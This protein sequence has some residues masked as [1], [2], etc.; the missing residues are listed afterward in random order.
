MVYSI[1]RTIHN[2][3]DISSL[4]GWCRMKFRIGSLLLLLMIIIPSLTFGEVITYNMYVGETKALSAKIYEENG[5]EL[6]SDIVWFSSNTSVAK[7]TNGVITAVNK[8]T[9]VISYNSK[10]GA[11]IHSGSVYVN[12]KSTVKSVEITLLTDSIRVGETQSTSVTVEAIPNIPV[13]AVTDVLYSSTDSSIFTVDKKGEI[14]GVNEGTAYLKV[15]TTDSARKDIIKV[16]VVSTVQ[17]VSIDKTVNKIHVGEKIQLETI[18]YPENAYLQ[19]VTWK[20]TNHV[21]ID[22]KGMATGLKEGTAYVSVYTVDGAKS[23]SVKFEVESMV[24]GIR[25]EENLIHISG[26][27]KAYQLNAVLLQ[28]K[29]GSYPYN[30]TI[31]WKSSNT[32]VASVSS[33]GLV[34]AKKDGA[35]NI[36]ATT[37]DGGYTAVA[38]VTIN[39]PDAFEISPTGVSLGE[40]S[41]SIQSGNSVIVP[42]S[43]EPQNTTEDTLDI[44]L[45][46]GDGTV[47]LKDGFVECTGYDEGRY[48]LKIT[49]ENGH[50]ATTTFNVNSN[51]KGVKIKSDALQR[52]S[53][54]GRYTLYL[55]QTGQLEH[56]LVKD[57]PGSV[58]LVDDVSWSSTDTKFVSVDNNGIYT[59]NRVGQTNIKIESKDSNHFDYLPV[60]VI[61]MAE[62]VS[63]PNHANIGLNMEYTPIPTFKLK[64]ELVGNAST[65]L[66]Q[67]YS[68]TLSSV[69]V[70]RVFIEAE[71]AFE[72]ERKDSLIE[73]RKSNILSDTTD[74]EYELGK[75]RSRLADLEDLLDQTDIVAD[76]DFYYYVEIKDKTQLTDRNY[77]TLAITYFTNGGKSIGSKLVS[78]FVIKI[79]TEDGALEDEMTIYA[80]GNT[81]EL[82][83]FDDRGNQIEA[84]LP[85]NNEMLQDQSLLMQSTDKSNIISDLRQGYG[86]LD[87]KKQPSDSNLIAVDDAKTLGLIQESFKS[88]YKRNITKLEMAKLCIAI[89][90]HFEKEQPDGF[91]YNVYMDTT[92]S[93]AI[94]AYQYGIVSVSSERLFYP[95]KEITREEMTYMFYK[96]IRALSMSIDSEKT[97]SM[98]QYFVDEDKI[99]DKFKKAVGSLSYQHSIVEGITENHF[100]PQVPNQIDSTLRYAV[101]LMNA[102]SSN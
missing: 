53:K 7:V 2:L 17:S 84:S 61:G 65:V 52:N 19:D 16:T 32:G 9:A 11:S 49:T 51:L 79:E 70:P 83:L 63:L 39:L 12:V 5:E 26:N 91:Q 34:T 31:E 33:K 4:K 8:G 62:E 92:D 14:K 22:N 86:T 1:N 36:T 20:S 55:G 66:N 100:W 74:V 35:V 57:N 13:Q 45:Y 46:G 80:D 38:V 90:D 15:E 44:K 30:D 87:I 77:N 99:Q 95:N 81:T 76:E 41:K 10:E 21:K 47:L 42:Y 93:D 27:N 72:E 85:V 89:F 71:I 75:S 18:F 67:D 58:I 94:K 98:D 50:F 54:N 68:M 3:V 6:D 60:E 69:S 97:Q 56:T 25:L 96:T 24:S 37:E 88:D 29:N 102:L 28:K 48:T 73:L 82:K 64:E 23:D 78:R 43:I 101:K 40:H 59:A